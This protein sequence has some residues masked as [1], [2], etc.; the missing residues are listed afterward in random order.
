MATN[1]IIGMSNRNFE[2][3]KHNYEIARYNA[4]LN[5]NVH[6]GKGKGIKNPKELGEFSWEKPLRK[7]R[8]LNKEAVRVLKVCA[9]RRASSSSHRRLGHV[10]FRARSPVAVICRMAAVIVPSGRVTVRAMA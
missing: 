2:M 10:I 8:K 1:A 4:A 3:I 6:L 7:K 5:I 9:S